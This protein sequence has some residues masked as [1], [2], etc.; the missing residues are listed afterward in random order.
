MSRKYVSIL[1]MIL[2]AILAKKGDP[3]IRSKSLWRWCHQFASVPY[4]YRL[5]LRCLPYFKY[6]SLILLSVGCFWGLFVA[7]TDFQ[8]GDAFRIIYIHVPAAFF[9]LCLYAIMGTLSIGYL[10]WR[11][12]LLDMLAFSMA[13]VGAVFT[14]I[15]LITGSLWG[16]PMWGTYWIWDARLT[17]ELIL[18]FLY[19]GYIALYH[20]LANHP[21]SGKIAAI[22]SAVGLLDLPIIHY[23]V[24]WWSTLH[25]GSTV[26]KLK[27]SIAPEMLY[28]LMIMLLGFA[29]Y[30]AWATLLRLKKTIQLREKNTK[31]LSEAV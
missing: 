15:A 3:L 27:P 4:V 28:P 29:C 14:L 6:A 23:S 7:P 18:L 20:S 10:I 24:T 9:S 12:K 25:Q 11:V 26:I 21:Q 30:A 1:K 17:S 13:P 8:Q 5:N 19:M 31:W 2:D 16:K 22:L